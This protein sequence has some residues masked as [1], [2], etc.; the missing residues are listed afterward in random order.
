MFIHPH[1]DI[2]IESLSEDPP[3]NLI[4]ILTQDGHRFT[5][6]LTG[7][8]DETAIAFLRRMIDGGVTSDL[9]ISRTESSFRAEEAPRPLPRHG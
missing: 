5:Y 2:E 9:V 8:L 1:H 7:C 3:E 4:K 6:H